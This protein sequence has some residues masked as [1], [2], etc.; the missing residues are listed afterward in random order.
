MVNATQEDIKIKLNFFNKTDASRTSYI[1]RINQ[2]DITV[3]EDI[4]NYFNKQL[5][6]YF[7]SNK[8][9][10]HINQINNDDINKINNDHIIYAVDGTYI[11]LKEKLHKYCKRA[12]NNSSVTCLVTGIFNITA[13]NIHVT[14]M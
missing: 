10:N 9:N 5:I 7:N 6:Y 13:N 3:F 1:K 8:H 2:I 12:K 14:N 11:Q 4:Y